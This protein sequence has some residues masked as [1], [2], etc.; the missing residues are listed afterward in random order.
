MEKPVV[1]SRVE[2]A[3]IGDLHELHE[4]VKHDFLHSLLLLLLLEPRR[5]E[6]LHEGPHELVELG[7]EPRVVDELG[8]VVFF[9]FGGAWGGARGGRER[10]EE[11]EEEG[12][13]GEEGL[14]EVVGRGWRG[15]EGEQEWEVVDVWGGR[16][17]L[18]A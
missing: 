13:E 3:T 14:E 7:S 18:P 17:E 10:G 16:E 15:H 4:R 1:Y 5:R 12:V 2:P 9:V 8:M 6:D 11:G